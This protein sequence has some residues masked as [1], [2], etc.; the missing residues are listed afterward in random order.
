MN[1]G[2]P[3]EITVIDLARAVLRAT[4]SDSRVV[5]R[6]LPGDDPQRR[7]PLID[8]ARSVLGFAPSVSLDDGLDATI[9]SLR[10]RL[11][12]EEPAPASRLRGPI[13]LRR[14]RT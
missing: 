5:F 3:A 11:D 7:R 10:D 13:E 2:N 9:E 6:P 12:I 8:R 14:Q 4:G 1:L